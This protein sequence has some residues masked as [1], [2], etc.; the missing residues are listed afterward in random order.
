MFCVSN[1]FSRFKKCLGTEKKCS[2]FPNLFTNSII[3]HVFQFCSQIQKKFWKFKKVNNFFVHK[4]KKCSLFSNLFTSLKCS[5]FTKI[6]RKFEKCFY[7]E[8][9]IHNFEKFSCRRSSIRPNKWTVVFR[10]FCE[11]M[12]KFSLCRIRL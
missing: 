7:F 6:V 2:S 8:E 1:L 5:C 10:I 3:V 4:F 9:N 12:F 11:L